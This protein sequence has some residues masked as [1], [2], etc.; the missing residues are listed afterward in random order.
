[1]LQFVYS[2]LESL[3]NYWGVLL[4]DNI[5]NKNIKSIHGANIFKD[6]ENCL[7]NMGNIVPDAIFANGAPQL[8]EGWVMV[9]SPD[10]LCTYIPYGAEK[11]SINIRSENETIHK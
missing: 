5:W 6:S 1:M 2:L 9:S 10:T 11:K 7:T 8:K 3:G 4:L